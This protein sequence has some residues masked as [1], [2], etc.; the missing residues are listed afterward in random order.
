ML[1]AIC[2]TCVLNAA[3]AALSWLPRSPFTVGAAL[4]IVCRSALIFCSAAFALSTESGDS[5]SPFSVSTCARMSELASQAWLLALSA[6]DCPP[7]QPVAASSASATTPITPIFMPVPSK[8]QTEHRRWRRGRATPATRQPGGVAADQT[9]AVGALTRTW[10]CICDT[11][12]HTG[13]LIGAHARGQLGLSE[14]RERLTGLP[15]V[16]DHE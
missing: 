15:E 7:P 4:A 1:S 12:V 8:R 10:L 5:G 14:P 9:A 3:F 11:R 13:H 16:D 6:D 2:C